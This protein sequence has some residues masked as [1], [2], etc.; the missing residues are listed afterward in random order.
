[1]TDA[2][3]ADPVELLEAHLVKTNRNG[4]QF[5]AA[6]KMDATVISRALARDRRPG[7]DS[8]IKIQTES[9]G[10]VPAEAWANFRYAPPRRKRAS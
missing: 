8:I 5:A 9:G 3:K 10:D 4:T 2:S 7:F 1:M 6:A